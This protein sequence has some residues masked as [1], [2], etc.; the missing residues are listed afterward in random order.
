VRDIGARAQRAPQTCCQN[1]VRSV[2]TTDEPRSP[3]GGK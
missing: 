2:T 3:A 1:G